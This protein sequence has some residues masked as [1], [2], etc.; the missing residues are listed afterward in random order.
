MESK[1]NRGLSFILAVCAILLFGYYEYNDLNARIIKWQV[2]ASDNRNLFYPEEHV[3][4]HKVEKAEDKADFTL[5]AK[6]AL[7]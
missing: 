3:E 1:F 4:N 2:N 5:C 6:S 7:L